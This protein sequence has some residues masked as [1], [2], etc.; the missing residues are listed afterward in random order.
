MPFA[1]VAIGRKNYLFA[2]SH[3]GADRAAIVYTLIANAKHAGVEPYA[4]LCDIISRI[5]DHPYHKLD[6][7]LPQNYTSNTK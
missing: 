6:Q 7:L 2:G 3:K 4:W 1:R 5:A